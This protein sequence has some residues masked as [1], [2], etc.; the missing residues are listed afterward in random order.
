MPSPQRSSAAIMLDLMMG[1]I[2]PMRQANSSMRVTIQ[3]SL[4]AIEA[5]HAALLAANE[6]IEVIDAELAASRTLEAVVASRGTDAC[7]VAD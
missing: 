4:E 6:L 1:T 5:T 2:Q 7:R 3:R